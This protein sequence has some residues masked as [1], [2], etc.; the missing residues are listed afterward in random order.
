MTT[1]QDE[2]KEYLENINFEDPDEGEPPAGEPEK[3]KEPPQEP[4]K[5]PPDDDIT[6]RARAI[7]WRP[8][9]DWKGDPSKWVTAEEYVA[10]GDQLLPVMKK[11]RE[12][13]FGEVASLKQDLRDLMQ[14]HK[15]DRTRIYARLKKE[16]E[17]ELADLKRKQRQAVED[18]D[19]STFDEIEQRMAQLERDR[20]ELQPIG[21][22][23]PA[24]TGAP[25]ADPAIFD[26][27]KQENPWYQ[28]GPD[29]QTPLN[30]MTR[31]A[32][33]LSFRV[34]AENPGL[35]GY[36]REFLD[37]VSVR[38]KE[39]YPDKF[40]NPRRNDPLGVE[41]SDMRGRRPSKKTFADLPPDAQEVCRRMKRHGMT[42]Q[43]YVSEYFGQ[44]GISL[45]D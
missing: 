13:L 23:P 22:T 21:Q 28:T 37:K 29:G 40:E 5:S 41:G 4:E 39:A 19:T 36:E 34:Q 1:N 43:Q 9:D 31:V 10:K 17:Q 11:D 3:P 27:W 45:E 35:S 12:K 25:Q 38:M 42:E 33:T 24:G 8:K 15:E 16:H 20:P 6:E 30:E 14:Y 44:E 32:Q 18:G 26:G 7:G 2:Q